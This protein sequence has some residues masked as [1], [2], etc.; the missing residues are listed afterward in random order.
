LVTT[1]LGK[2]RNCSFFSQISHKNH[3]R[4]TDTSIFWRKWNSFIFAKNGHRFHSGSALRTIFFQ[5]ISTK[6]GSSRTSHKFHSLLACRSTVLRK[7]KDGMTANW[8]RNYLFGRK[9]N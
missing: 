3:S 8:S 2:K 1:D 6:K 7:R 9:R 4:R 5:T